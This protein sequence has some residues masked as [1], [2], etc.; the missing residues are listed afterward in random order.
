MLRVP[1]TLCVILS[2]A[3][4]KSN[5]NTNMKI[6]T[7]FSAPVKTKVESGIIADVQK[8][9]LEHVTVLQH[10]WALPTGKYY[11]ELD[12]GNS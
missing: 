5:N 7:D 11:G 12:D 1:P 6:K 8:Y 3:K 2:D 10:E 9:Q 4:Y